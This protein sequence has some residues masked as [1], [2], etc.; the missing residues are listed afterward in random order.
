MI[1]APILMLVVGLTGPIEV[2]GDVMAQVAPAAR[3]APAASGAPPLVQK[4]QK[5]PRAI[6]RVQRSDITET[7]RAM[8]LMQIGSEPAPSQRTGAN[9]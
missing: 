5:R 2:E 4:R 1:S 3:P 8:S 7:L 6:R 9:Q